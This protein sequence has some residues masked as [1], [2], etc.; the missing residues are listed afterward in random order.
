MMKN[1]LS[2]QIVIQIHT[3]QTSIVIQNHTNWEAFGMRLIAI[4]AGKFATKAVALEGSSLYFRTKSTKVR[5][6]LDID[7]SGNSYKVQLDKGTYIIGDQGEESD[8][9]L[10]KNSLLHKLAIYTAI[11]QLGY[12]G[13]V[14]I[15]IGCPASLYMSKDNRRQYK[16]YIKDTPDIFKLN[17]KTLDIMIDEALVMPES[18]GVVYTNVGLFN[19]NRVA[20]IDIGG[21]NMNFTIYDNLI[22]EINSMMTTNQGSMEIETMVKKKFETLYKTALSARDIQQI[23]NQGGLKYRGELQIESV[24][25]LK[26]IMQEYSEKIVST[27]EKDFSL[28]TLEVVITGGTGSLIKD[29]ILKQIPHAILAPESQ[30]TNVKGFLNIAKVRFNG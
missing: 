14:N 17:D 3:A 27:I 28:N 12:D 4:D 10:E 13:V 9:S 7:T 21:R 8:H 19:N 15:V 11:G 16:D 20:V 23:I 30:W 2:E 26:E 25:A 18:S 29:E 22:P 6:N 5:E 24:K 1:C